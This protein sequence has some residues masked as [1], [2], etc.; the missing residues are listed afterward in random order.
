MKLFPKRHINNILYFS[1]SKVF[2]AAI[3]LLLTKELFLTLSSQSFEKYSMVSSLSITLASFTVGWL[4][5]SNIRYAMKYKKNTEEINSLVSSLILVLIFFSALAYVIYYNIAF[6]ISI[7]FLSIAFN[8]LSLS[9]FQSL[10]KP[11]WV[12]YQELFRSVILVIYII[13]VY[14]F[15][16]NNLVYAIAW[17]SISYLL[18]SLCIYKEIRFHSSINFY[19]LRKYLKYGMPMS[20]WLVISTGYPTLERYILSK[21]YSGNDLSDYFAMNELLVR[22]AGIVFTPIM[23]YL[24]PLLMSSFDKSESKFNDVLFK[25]LL[26][27]CVSSTCIIII[28]ALMS[29]SLIRLV[30][31]DIN[32]NIINCSFLILCIPALWQLCFLSHKKLEALGK[33]SI[34][35]LFIFISLTIFTLLT[36]LLVPVSG[37]WSGVFSQ[38]FSLIIYILLVM[39]YSK[40]IAT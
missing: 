9:Y 11:K 19:G 16:D 22:G 34:L 29:D 18:P 2:P 3:I 38:I 40:R 31:P 14:L 26:L 12:F 17:I 37:I 33:T 32:Q 23:M 4:S 28:Y 27:L 6:L 15:D 21:M 10:I 24:H 30:F 7:L 1:A 36:A 20:I 5:Q 8:R 35:S 13:S 39:F 25:A